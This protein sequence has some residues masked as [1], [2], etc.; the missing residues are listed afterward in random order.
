MANR[1]GGAKPSH[2]V[3][4]LLPRDPDDERSKD[5]WIELGAAWVTSGGAISFQL[6]AV[7]A[8]LMAGRAVRIVLNPIQDRGSR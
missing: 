4:F 3:S 6:A 1:T 7:P 5:R 2:T 8:P